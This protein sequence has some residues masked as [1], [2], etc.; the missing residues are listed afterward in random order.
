[1]QANSPARQPPE[2]RL[3]RKIRDF[4]RASLRSHGTPPASLISLPWHRAQIPL[5]RA[6]RTRYSQTDKVLRS[7]REATPTVLPVLQDA[8][9]EMMRHNDRRR[10]QLVAAQYSK[11]VYT[12]TSSGSPLRKYA[13]RS[14]QFWNT[15]NMPTLE[16]LKLMA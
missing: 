16:I 3:S 12:E 2:P 10:F 15:Q 6:H 13:Y 5:R 14:I 11:T 4:H 1:M 7:S 9:M 8:I